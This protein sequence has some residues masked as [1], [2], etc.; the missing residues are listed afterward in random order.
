MTGSRS[1]LPVTRRNFARD[2]DDAVQVGPV[3]RDFQ[4]VNHIAAGAAQIFGERLAD[5]RVRA[6]DEI[7][8]ICLPSQV[9]AANTSCPG[10]RRRRLFAP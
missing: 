1:G 4:I 9:P 10:S 6:Q 2:A 7:H 5:L 8:R 3:R